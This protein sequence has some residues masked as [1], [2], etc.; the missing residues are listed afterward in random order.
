[1][2]PGDLRAVL[3]I[4][5]AVH[6]DY[7]ESEAVFAERL[8]LFPAGCLMLESGGAAAGYATAHP[9]YHRRPPALDV[10]LGAL[11]P[12]PEVLYLHDLALLPAA[13][14]AGAGRVAIQRLAALA[15][16]LPM[17]L[18]AI[19]GTE[20]FWRAQG[21]AATSDPALDDILRRYDHAARYMERSL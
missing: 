18:V 3:A 2:A 19:A 12:V 16:G 13:R 5:A 8:A 1:M 20:E 11:P 7:P 17:A 10:L 9:W 14:G 6:P 15:G 4:A 21:F